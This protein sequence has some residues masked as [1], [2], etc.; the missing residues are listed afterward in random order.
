ML[1]TLILMVMF[2]QVLCSRQHPEK[3]KPIQ[4]PAS[5]LITAALIARCC[6]LLSGAIVHNT[7]AIHKKEANPW[8]G[9]EALRR[10]AYAPCCGLTP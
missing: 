2:P 9:F 3:T 10:G 1:P 8:A 7:P 6:D 4:G 5:G